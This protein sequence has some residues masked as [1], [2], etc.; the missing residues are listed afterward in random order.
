MFTSETGQEEVVGYFRDLVAFVSLFFLGGG[1]IPRLFVVGGVL[2]Q[3][4]TD[5]QVTHL[6]SIV[7]PDPDADS[8]D[9]EDDEV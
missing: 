1:G 5:V 4:A 7:M 2:M 3:E 9:D 8:D 6:N